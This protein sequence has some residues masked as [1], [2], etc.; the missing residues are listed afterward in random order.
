MKSIQHLVLYYQ[1][2]YQFIYV[3]GSLT[4]DAVW[5]FKEHM[6]WQALI[7]K[8]ENKNFFIFLLHFPVIE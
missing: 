3:L 4:H 8:R 6:Q 2:M 5:G 1:I 7:N